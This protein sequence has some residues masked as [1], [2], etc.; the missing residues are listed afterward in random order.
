[1]RPVGVL[2]SAAE[3][4]RVLGAAFEDDVPYAVGLIE[5]DDGPRMYGTLVGEPGSSELDCRVR[6][7]VPSR[8]WEQV[9]RSPEPTAPSGDQAADRC[10]ACARYRPG[11]VPYSLAK[12]CENAYGLR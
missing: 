7:G 11:V 4:Q 8:D 10:A 9:W 2:S 1:M 12:A 5:L 3:Y 6:A